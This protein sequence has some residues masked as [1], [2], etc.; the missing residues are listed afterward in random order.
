MK[1]SLQRFADRDMI[2]LSALVAL[3]QPTSGQCS[4]EDQVVDTLSVYISP[5]NQSMRGHT[6]TTDST[7]QRSTLS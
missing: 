3:A 4:G 1:E 6:C 7:S 5:P 2:Y